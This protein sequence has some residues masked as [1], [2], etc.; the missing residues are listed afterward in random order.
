MRNPVHN[1]SFSFFLVS[2]GGSITQFF[3]YFLLHTNVVN[4]SRIKI[5]KRGITQK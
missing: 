5:Y 4:L 2:F 1:Y 3:W